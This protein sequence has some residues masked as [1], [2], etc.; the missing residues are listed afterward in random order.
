MGGRKSYPTR[1]LLGSGSSVK[2]SF[3]VLKQ[4]LEK[5]D[6]KQI[7]LSTFTVFS[8]SEKT[9]GFFAFGT[10]LSPFII[11]NY[12]ILVREKDDDVVR[13]EITKAW[14]N[15]KEKNKIEVPKEVD[16]VIIDNALKSIRGGS[17]E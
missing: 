9:V 1:N 15:I 8:S 14:D 10:K 3:Q 11:R 12:S 6:S 4:S 5:K 16:K 13:R 2:K 17:N 7:A